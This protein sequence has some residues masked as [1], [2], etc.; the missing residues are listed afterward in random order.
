MIKKLHSTDDF[1]KRCDVFGGRV[2]SAHTGR[3]FGPVHPQMRYFA[4]IFQ[5]LLDEVKQEKLLAPKLAFN[6]KVTPIGTDYEFARGQGMLDGRMQDIDGFLRTPE[7][8][9]G[10]VVSITGETHAK[11]A[12]LIMNA[13]CGV[14]K[15]LAPDGSL[16]VMH[17]G[18]D[19]VDNKDGSSIVVNAIEYFKSQ[20]IAPEDLRF[21][22]GEAARACCYGFNDPAKEGENRARSSRLIQSYGT[23]VSTVVKNPPRKGG[24]GIDVPLIAARQAEKMGVKDVNVEGICTSCYGLN[25]V[26]MEAKDQFGQWF[27]NLREDSAAVKSRGYGLRNAVVVY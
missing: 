22:I 6:T 4:G 20:G 12:V 2:H 23:D 10:V 8:S 18:L 5:G 24:I 26:F 14:G 16:A 1:G 7:A 9:D 19:N 27:S 17:C 11:I 21:Q 25:S 3:Q 13:D 15:I